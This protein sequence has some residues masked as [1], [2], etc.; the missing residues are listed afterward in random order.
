DN[1]FAGYV[2][3]GEDILYVLKSNDKT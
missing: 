2:A 3:A 1:W